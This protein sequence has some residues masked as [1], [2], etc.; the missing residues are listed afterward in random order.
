MD[1]LDHETP[2]EDLEALIAISLMAAR[3]DI[4]VEVGSWVGGTTKELASRFLRVYAVDHWQGS[5]R[6]EEI[7]KSLGRDA[8][9][10]AFCENIGEALFSTVFPLCGPSILWSQVFNKRADLVFIDASH[11]YESVKSDI[12]AWWP[13]VKAGGILCGHDYNTH[14]GVQQSVDEFGKDGV[15]ANVWWRKKH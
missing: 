1:N 4:A 7:V 14:G 8:I 11:D 13:H 12:A 9:F 2:A 5:E 10:K 6:L 15:I 3:R